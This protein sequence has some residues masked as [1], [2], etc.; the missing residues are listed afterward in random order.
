MLSH[1]WAELRE[2]AA[3]KVWPVKDIAL[4]RTESESATRGRGALE[5][6]FLPSE[7][8]AGSDISGIVRLV[9]GSDL[10]IRK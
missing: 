6:L 8:E 3:G 7:R 5:V 2:Q 9:A 1:K 4:S 10:P